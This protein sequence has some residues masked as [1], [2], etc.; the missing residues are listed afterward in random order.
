MQ[1]N[2]LL[3]LLFIISLPVLETNASYVSDLLKFL[4]PNIGS[5]FPT[6]FGYI[7]KWTS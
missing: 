4:R 3:L 1:A 7:R 5:G 2:L 6:Q